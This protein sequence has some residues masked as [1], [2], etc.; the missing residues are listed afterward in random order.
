[1]KSFLIIVIVLCIM[2][3]CFFIMKPLDGFS[4]KTKKHKEPKEKIKKPDKRK[5]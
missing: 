2:T 5:D 4:Q 1:M 3:F